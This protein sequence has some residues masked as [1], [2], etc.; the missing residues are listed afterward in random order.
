M[1][2][3]DESLRSAY[4]MLLEADGE[5]VALQT[6]IAALETAVETR[7]EEVKFLRIRLTKLEDERTREK[8]S[9]LR[10]QL[11]DDA[12]KCISEH[13]RRAA[14]TVITAYEECEKFRHLLEQQVSK[15]KAEV[16]CLRKEKEPPII[17]GSLLEMEKLRKINRELLHACSIGNPV[18]PAASDN[19]PRT[20][21]VM[22]SGSELVPVVNFDSLS[23]SFL[24]ELNVDADN[25]K[26]SVRYPVS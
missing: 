9:V 8:I 14:E 4:N 23:K 6:R 18:Q 21:P 16:A 17:S 7:H 1:Q 15:L 13:K 12:G 22:Y 5:I 2:T 10:N 25:P 3:I 24:D 20:P 11:T 19:I 26:Y